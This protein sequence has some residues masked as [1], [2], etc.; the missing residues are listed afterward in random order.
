MIIHNIIVIDVLLK[1][2][3]KIRHVKIIRHKKIE[4]KG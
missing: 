3:I 4:N 1:F 2:V